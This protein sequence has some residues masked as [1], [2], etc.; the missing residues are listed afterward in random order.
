MSGGSEARYSRIASGLLA[1]ELARVYLLSVW[2][3]PK[4]LDLRA[5][6]GK[7]MSTFTYL[8]NLARDRNIASVTPTSR[9]GV[10]RILRCMDFT[11][12][13]VIVEYG[14]GLGVFTKK[15]LAHMSADSLLIAIE[16]NSDFARSLIDRI[17]DPRL[18][19][20]NDSAENV[21][22]I[23][24]GCGAE[25][26]DYIISG[27]PFSLFPVE[28]KDRILKNTGTALAKDGRFFVYQFWALNPKDKAD[29]R[30]KLAEHMQVL[31]T[32]SEFLNVPPLRI[33][34]ATAEA[35]TR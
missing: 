19:V 27:I 18:Q 2:T 3:W 9:F 35:R 20:I 1:F 15:L 11:K 7:C 16:T 33:F 14:P 10:R 17:P 5:E 29:I 4:C 30:H 23:L 32:D 13:R 34:E 6:W 24:N 28:L 25:K 26:A 21:L 12:A 22:S 8:K 31:R